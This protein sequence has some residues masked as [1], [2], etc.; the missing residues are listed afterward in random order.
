MYKLKRALTFFDALMINLGAIIGAGIFVI[1]G[2]AVNAAG[3][4]IV[5]AIALA[6]IVSLLSGL[7]FSEIALHVAKE[8]GVYEYAKDA[9]APSAGFLAGWMWTIGNVIAIAAVGLSFGSY[10]NLLIGSTMPSAYYAIAAIIAFAVINILGIK[11]SARTI[12]AMVGI[13]LLVLSLFVAFS[14]LHFNVANLSNFAPN[15]ANGILAGSALIFFAFTGFSRVT[16]VSDEVKD[17]RRTIPKAII[18]SIII[19]SLL[20]VLIALGAVGLVPYQQFEHSA[21]PLSYAIGSLHIAALSIAVAIGGVVAT[22]GVVFTGILGVSRVFFAMGRD[23]ELP[24][25][26][27]Y[28][29]RFSTPINAIALSSVLA[30]LFIL[31]MPF[32]SIVELSNA[33]ILTA[34]A[35]I[36]ISALSLWLRLEKDRKAL[37]RHRLFFAIPIAGFATIILVMLYLGAKSLALALL[38]FAIGAIYY[39]YRNLRL[40]KG[41]EAYIRKEIPMHSVVR[42]FGQSRERR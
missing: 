7:S 26:L 21:A 32:K 12:A 33:G 4:A 38:I 13:N 11:H 1:I 5:I 36:N 9:F 31:F 16:T 25:K 27:S 19:S 42:E 8:G 30:V 34:Y 14:I 20:Y 2:L 40:A 29:D 24:K 37:I 17:P 39:A 3:P 28:I 22:A 10:F 23:N 35:I 41:M 15:G 18:A 6:A